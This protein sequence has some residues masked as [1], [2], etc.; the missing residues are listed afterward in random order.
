MKKLA[1]LLLA[2]SSIFFGMEEQEEHVQEPADYKNK[3]VAL[4]FDQSG[5]P[6]EL[7]E[8]YEQGVGVMWQLWR[9]GKPLSQEIRDSYYPNNYALTR[10]DDGNLAVQARIWTMNCE[11]DVRVFASDG[12]E[13]A[14]FGA[15][16]P[17]ATVCAANGSLYTVDGFRDMFQVAKWDS[18]QGNSVTK[19]LTCPDYDYNP[20][21]G[22]SCWQGKLPFRAQPLE[23]TDL[24]LI[25]LESGDLDIIV[26][27]DKEPITRACITPEGIL[28]YGCGKAAIA[29]LALSD[30]RSKTVIAALESIYWAPEEDELN[31][32]KD[33]LEGALVITPKNNNPYFVTIESDGAEQPQAVVK[34]WDLRNAQSG[35][36][37]STTK[38]GM[39]YSKMCDLSADGKQLCGVNKSGAVCTFALASESTVAALRAHELECE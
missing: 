20:P 30:A 24:G 18:E 17:M 39:M 14:W 34:L 37:V 15:V 31:S 25:D 26:S 7:Q 16:G 9:D 33:I 38:P 32:P 2:S 13:L 1:L 12:T 19:Q 27:H 21:A 10:L 6:V 28:F 3:V 29:T 23:G 36:P 4:C 5:C 8:T 11:K 22:V 35:N